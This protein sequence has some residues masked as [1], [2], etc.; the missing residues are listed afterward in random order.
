MAT[1][2]EFVDA[3]EKMLVAL[4]TISVLISSPYQIVQWNAISTT[5]TEP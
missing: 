1:K 2:P 5:T 4:V 3:K